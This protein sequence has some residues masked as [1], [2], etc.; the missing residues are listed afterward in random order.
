MA[1]D[2][3]SRIFKD[4]INRNDLP[5]I[6]FHDLHHANATLMLASGTS[7]KVAS[8]RLGHSAI[9]ITMDLYTHVLQGLE[10]EAARN[11]SDLIY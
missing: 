2:S 8:T 11:I 1:S 5:N 6:R 9:G 10:E 3:F 4:F 7:M